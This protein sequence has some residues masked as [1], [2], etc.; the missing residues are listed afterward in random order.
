MSVITAQL[1]AVQRSL[2]IIETRLLTVLDKESKIMALVDDLTAA[3]AAEQ[4][5][6]D[7]LG[8]TLGT[9]AT[10]ITAAIADLQTANPN[11]PAIT[12]AV[13]A[14]QAHTATLQAMADSAA[15]SSAALAAALPAAPAPVV[16][17]TNP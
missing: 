4:P 17:P 8:A 1:A 10:E 12:A 16:P 14:L 9:L 3:V 2:L 6:L 11:D 7:N 15:Q 5:K 13:T